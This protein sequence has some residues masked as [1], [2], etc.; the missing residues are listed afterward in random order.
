MGLFSV[1]ISWLASLGRGIPGLFAAYFQRLEGA[2]LPWAARQPEHWPVP[3]PEHRKL[4][5]GHVFLWW[6]ARIRSYF[7]TS[8][9][10]ITWETAT[11]GNVGLD[12]AFF[13]NALSFSVDYFDKRTSDILIDLPVAATFGAGAP[14]QNAAKVRN[15]AGK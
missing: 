5:S 11:M 2:R 1:G 8:N 15:Q 4:G 3:L 10:D 7:S 12:L 6:H 14:T 9:A 13:Q